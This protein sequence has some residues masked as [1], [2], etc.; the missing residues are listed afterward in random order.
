MVCL[1][2]VYIFVCKPRKMLDRAW[3]WAKTNKKWRTNAVHGEEEIRIVLSDSFELENV[4]IEET[5]RTGSF[6]VEELGL[7]VSKAMHFQP[8]PF[9]TRP[10][11]S[12]SSSSQATATG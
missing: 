7:F 1:I 3:E 10:G 9:T 6:E 8:G 4:E 5:T 11:L 12:F 2:Y